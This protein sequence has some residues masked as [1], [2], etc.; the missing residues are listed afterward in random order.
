MLAAC[1]ERVERM[2]TLLGR[3]R[4]HLAQHGCDA[5]ARQAAADVMRYFDVAA[6]RHHEDEEL[7]VFP[8]LLVAGDEAV[9][10]V[11]R[12][13]QQD[14]L[15]MAL[16][17]AQARTVLDRVVQAGDG[18]G[19]VLNAHEEAALERFAGV[20]GRHIEDEDGLVYPQAR[21]TL[22]QEALQAMG[23]DMMARRGV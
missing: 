2:L 15:D 8:P 23:E 7:H 1:H 12:R 6:P 20:Y 11:V 17:W 10:A 14:H 5:Q 22:T 13:L 21:R 4:A 18:S 9:K 3:L 16:N 19:P